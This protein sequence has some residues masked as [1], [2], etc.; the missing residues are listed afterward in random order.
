MTS[1]EPYRLSDEHAEAAQDLLTAAFLTA[2]GTTFMFP[3]P[4]RGARLLPPLFTAIARRTVHYGEATT[5]GEPLH[6]S[7]VRFLHPT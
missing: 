6:H 3:D 7:L 1:T 4:A 5:P 2:P